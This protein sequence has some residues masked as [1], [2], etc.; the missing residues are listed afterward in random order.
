MTQ[1]LGSLYKSLQSRQE[2]FDSMLKLG[3][4]LDMIQ[5][6]MERVQQQSEDDDV[7]IFDA[8][9]SDSN[10]ESEEDDSELDQDFSDIEE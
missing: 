2:T 10:M 9:S 1:K 6:Q 4:K 8:N 7:V 5:F 3:G